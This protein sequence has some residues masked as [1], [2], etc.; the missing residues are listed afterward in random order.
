MYFETISGTGGIVWSTGVSSA[1][2]TTKPINVFIIRMTSS[3]SITGYLNIY[4]IGRW[5]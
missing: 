2:P 1:T 4:A 3:A 5:K